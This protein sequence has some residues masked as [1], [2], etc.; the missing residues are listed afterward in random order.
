M[1]E[2][3]VEFAFEGHRWWDL[4]RWRQADKIWTGSEMCIDAGT[5]P[6]FFMYPGD[7]HNMFGRDRVHLY[8]RI[9]RYFEDHL[10]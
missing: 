4:K 7:G 2:N 1:H 10:K 3:Q 9:T 6:D 8:E 5:Q